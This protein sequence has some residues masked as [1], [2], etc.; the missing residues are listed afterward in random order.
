MVLAKRHAYQ[1]LT[2]RATN[3]LAY[4]S[5][6]PYARIRNLIDDPS[7]VRA[8]WFRTLTRFEQEQAQAQWW[9]NLKI[10][11]WPPRNVWLGVSVENQQFEPTTL[12][13][14]VGQVLRAAVPLCGEALRS[15]LFEWLARKGRQDLGLCAFCGSTKGANARSCA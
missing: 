12:A 4:M 5:S 9:T 6:A 10:E 2:K 8:G 15:E 3:M 14:F 7:V 1:V 13:L 11:D